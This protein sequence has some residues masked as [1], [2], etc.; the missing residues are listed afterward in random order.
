[1]I[2][3]FLGFNHW[4]ALQA[5]PPLLVFCWVVLFTAGFLVGS[6]GGK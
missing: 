6:F 3:D 5:L 4:S 2:G 1:M